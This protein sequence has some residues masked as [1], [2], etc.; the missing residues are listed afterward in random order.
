MA[1][2]KNAKDIN[3]EDL[4]AQIIAKMNAEFEAKQEQREMNS[5]RLGARVISKRVVNGSP[6]VDKTTGEQKVL[7]GIPQT[8]SDKYYVVL[9]LV[10]AELETE[11][12]DF[13]VFDSLEENKT[14][15]CEGRI[16]EVKN[17]GVSSLAPIIT[18]FTKI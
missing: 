12:K 2:I 5:V 9:Q 13:T 18:K 16:G 3:I 6:I 11:I 10:G 14:Y 4:E 1:T 15:F 17:Y 7:G 8:Y